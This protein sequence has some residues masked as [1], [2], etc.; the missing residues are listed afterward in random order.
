MIREKLR[1]M[2]QKEGE[3]RGEVREKT[4]SYVSTA[5]GRDRLESVE[6]AGSELKREV[7]ER[8]IGYI[9]A[10]LGLVA[11]LAWNDAIRALIEFLFP[12]GSG[13]LFAK[14]LYALGVT[15]VAVVVSTY[16]VRLIRKE[17]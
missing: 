17:E 11:G 12:G 9:V 7:R 1:N 16:L 14:F 4:K 6:R 5:I 8:T 3:F 10:A 15:L 13:T 2:K